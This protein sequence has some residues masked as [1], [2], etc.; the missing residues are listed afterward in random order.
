MGRLH[1]LPA[2]RRQLPPC[3][4]AP[5]RT[6]AGSARSR[7]GRRA[8]GFGYVSGDERR[9]PLYGFL[10]AGDFWA[11]PRPARHPRR[12]GMK[13]GARVTLWLWSPEA[14]PMDLRP[15]TAWRP[16][17][18]PRSSSKASAALHEDYEPRLLQHLYSY[19]PVPR[20]CCSG[21]TPPP[22]APRHSPNRWRPYAYCPSLGRPA[23]L[24]FHPSAQV[25]GPGLCSEPDRSTPA[26]AKI[27]DYLDFPLHLLQGPGGAAPL[28]R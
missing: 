25:F 21:P 13:Q 23:G 5:R 11:P 9:T 19:S 28:V 2:L 6:T 22:R 10:P 27:E 18:L 3:A 12:Q 26:K 14:Q 8:S 17:H 20:N 1:P 4:S 15:P 16:G 24:A 7:F